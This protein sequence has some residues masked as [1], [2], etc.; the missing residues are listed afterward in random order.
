MPRSWP[1]AAKRAPS[2]RRRRRGLGL[3]ARAYDDLLTGLARAVRDALVDRELSVLL[4]LD[5][6]PRA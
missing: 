2:P 6:V 5:G 4:D 3:S 1:R